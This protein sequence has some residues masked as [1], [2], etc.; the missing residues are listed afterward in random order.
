MIKQ[1]DTN[2]EY[3]R[4]LAFGLQ[5]QLNRVERAVYRMLKKQR[6]DVEVF[7]SL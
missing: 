5:T 3:L 7:A 4:T 1:K 2:V 6:E